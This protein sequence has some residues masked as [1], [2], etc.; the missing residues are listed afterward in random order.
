MTTK[1]RGGSSRVFAISAAVIAVSVLVAGI[2]PARAQQ[3]NVKPPPVI[4]PGTQGKETSTL[5]LPSMPAKQGGDS[6]NIP[7]QVPQAAQELVLPTQELRQQP[8]Y[9]Q[10]TVTVT[11]PNGTYVTGLQKQDFKLYLDGQQ[12]PIQFF[13]QDLNTP[14]SIGI[15]VDTSGS[16]VTK[17][18]QVRAATV[19]FIR[20]LNDRDDIFIY[21]FSTRPFLLQAFT[22]N[23]EMVLSKLRLLR[24]GGQTAL[25]DVILQG[26][27]TVQRGRYDKKALLVITD[28]VDNSSAST[29]DDVVRQARRMGVLVYSIGIGNPHPGAGAT[30]AIGPFSTM[31]GGDEDWVDAETLHTLS[32]E[33]GAKTYII[34]QAGD[35]EL[36]RRAC[37]NISLEL[38]EQYT[39]G[40]LAP[41]PGAGGYRKLRVEVPGKTRADVRVRKGVEV[42][43]GSSP[44]GYDPAVAGGPPR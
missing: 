42:G 13:R 25:F 44:A 20:N 39:V 2:V 19:E 43:R 22:T 1:L 26:L 5:E 32:T 36:L 40:F 6:L 8:G 31:I 29:V 17:I 18:P 34:A 27:N 38:R 4:M 21:A 23:H 11:D 10:V 41:D 14:V 12:R 24:P 28:G 3:G 33:T 35:G 9:E 7:P 15:V 30:F 37:A 16:M